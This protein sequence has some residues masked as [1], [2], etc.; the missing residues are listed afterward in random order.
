MG[1]AQA[2]KQDTDLRELWSASAACGRSEGKGDSRLALTEVP[3]EV[4]R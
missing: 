1:E 4:D 2:R 3:D